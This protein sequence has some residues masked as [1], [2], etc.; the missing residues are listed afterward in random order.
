MRASWPG[1][2]RAS[3]VLPRV[4]RRLRRLRRSLQGRW[5]KCLASMQR[6][7]QHAES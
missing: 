4:R 6:A 5:P 2:L 3:C 7:E 1:S